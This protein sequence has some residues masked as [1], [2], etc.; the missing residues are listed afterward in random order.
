MQLIS[1]T[2]K[3][4]TGHNRLHSNSLKFA[5]PRHILHQVF[6]DQNKMAFYVFADLENFSL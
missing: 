2:D 3:I 5:D 4:L 6:A 1:I